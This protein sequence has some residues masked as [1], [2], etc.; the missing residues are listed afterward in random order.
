MTLRDNAPHRFVVPI[1]SDGTEYTAA[2]PLPILVQQFIAAG[3]LSYH[4]EVALGN[5]TGRSTVNKFGAAPDGVQTTA[6]DIWDRANSTPTQQVWTAPTQARIHA[7]V[8][9]SAEDAAGGTGAASVI[10]Y[11]LT[12]W[13]TNEVSETITLTGVTP[14]NTTNSYVIIHRMKCVGQASTTGVGVNIG[15]ITAT[16]ASDNTVTA[17]ILAGNGQTEMAIYG[18]PSTKKALLLRWSG[19]INKTAA[20]AA[21][22]DFEIRVNENPNVQLLGF[23]RK[24]DISVQS[25]GANV[26]ERYYPVPPV[27]TGPCIIKITGIASAADI[28]AHAEF[29]IELVDL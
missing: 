8:S 27:Y 19:G 15:T 18:V 13:S 17:A 24:D 2:N 20:S 29:D 1:D 25:T 5:V 22:C 12:S 4:S 9:T 16:A 28:D 14:V 26:H 23:L 11:G 7:V 6:T 10:V 3:M 21:T